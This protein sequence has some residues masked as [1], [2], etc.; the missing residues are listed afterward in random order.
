MRYHVRHDL[1]V[2]LGIESGCN[3]VGRARE[4]EKA[5]DVVATLIDKHEGG[6]AGE[7]PQNAVG[8][9]DGY[10][11]D[12]QLMAGKRY[13]NGEL[14]HERRF[15]TDGDSDDKDVAPTEQKITNIR[16]MFGPV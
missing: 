14:H 8:S 15:T 12:N 16:V 13:I 7:A 10:G 11:C 5:I 3:D 1:E 2:V 9:L 6:L 4:L